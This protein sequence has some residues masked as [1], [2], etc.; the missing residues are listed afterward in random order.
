TSFA[1]NET[2]NTD[3]H[4]FEYVLFPYSSNGTVDYC[5]SSTTVCRYVGYRNSKLPRDRYCVAVKNPNNINYYMTMV[6]T[7]GGTSARRDLDK[8]EDTFKKNIFTREFDRRDFKPPEKDV[9]D[10]FHH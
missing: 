4:G 10:R 9:G 3:Y 7:F 6:F 8:S 1:G 5:G 2:S